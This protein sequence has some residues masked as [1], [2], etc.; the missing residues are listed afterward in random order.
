[1]NNTFI[2]A[3]IKDNM[4]QLNKKGFT[5]IELL[6]VI[7]IIGVLGSIVFAPF[8][9]ARK[10]GRDGKRIAE[11]KGVQSSLL[12]FSEDNSGCFPD[13]AAASTKNGYFAKASNKYITSTLFGKIAPGNAAAAMNSNLNAWTAN[14]PY[15]LR[16]IGDDAQCTK[17]VASDPSFPNYQL[18]VE[19]ETH[20][21]GLDGDADGNMS[22][23]AF[24]G[25]VAGTADTKYDGLD[26]SLTS[27]PETCASSGYKP[28]VVSSAAASYQCV[29]DLSNQ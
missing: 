13:T 23:A 5:L 11:L 18:F 3:L 25:K 20:T 6:V 14:A 21:T 4:L 27:A 24:N 12:L 29:F 15:T 17:T 28:G 2:N 7:A 10:K 1:M 16:S 22:I 8:N 19:L 26:L 9:E